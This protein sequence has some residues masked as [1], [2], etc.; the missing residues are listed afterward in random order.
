MGGEA[1]P[2]TAP[3]VFTY[4]VTPIGV[5]VTMAPVTLRLKERGTATESVMFITVEGAIIFPSDADKKEMRASGYQTRVGYFRE[6]DGDRL[7]HVYGVH[8]DHDDTSGA[9]PVYHSQMRSMAKFVPDINTA[10]RMEF[11]ALDD[12]GDLVRSILR[13]VRI[14][15][16]HMDPFSVLIQI[17]GDHLVSGVKDDKVTAA[18]ERLRQQLSSFRSLP[19][20][21]VRLEAVM[22]ETCFRSSHWYN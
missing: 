5:E 19:T 20:S 15:T 16:A 13:N 14:P 6:L 12:E 21:A 22:Q 11:Q 17:A 18:F 2:K 9:H 8:Y 3:D 4:A 7:S 1:K 10:Y